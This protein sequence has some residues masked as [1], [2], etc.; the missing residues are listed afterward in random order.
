MPEAAQQ[1]DVA[2]G[3]PSVP[4]PC[5]DGDDELVVCHVAELDDPDLTIVHVLARLQLVARRSGHRAVFCHAPPALVE[6][7]ELAGLA[8]VL[9][10][11]SGVEVRGESEEGEQALRAEEG[12]HRHDLPP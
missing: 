6:L 1:K 2:G 10:L 8:G 4:T 3:C 12:V 9:D 5:P 7:V 11:R